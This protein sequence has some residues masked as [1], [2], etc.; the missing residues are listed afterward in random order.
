MTLKASF[1]RLLLGAVAVVPALAFAN[2]QAKAEVL[3]DSILVLDNFVL[4]SDDSGTPFTLADVELQ[5]ATNTANTGG[6]GLVSVPGSL[7]QLG[8]NGITPPGDV[9]ADVNLTGISEGAS[10]IGDDNYS[11]ALT[12]PPTSHFAYADSD[13]NGVAI[14][15]GA[16]TVG[17]T[18][19]TRAA[20]GLLT[21]DTG[22][23]NAQTGL[24]ASFR[25]IA[26]ED[27]ELWVDFDYFVDLVAF[28]STDPEIADA[29]A[30]TR[31][32]WSIQLTDNNTGVVNTL[33]P[34]EINQSRGRDEISDG[35]LTLSDSGHLTLFLGNLISGNLY[36]LTIT[37]QVFAQTQ[38]AL[39][40]IPEPSA[41][42]LFGSGLVILALFGHRFG[43]RRLT[44][45]D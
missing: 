36:G 19:Q 5:S 25:F 28:V 21:S 24:Q 45:P 17:V 34:D 11:P 14:D 8:T 35:T 4:A 23:A 40:A 33:S 26:V 22:D 37:H 31:S 15:V 39:Q 41:L 29:V 42:L 10:P 2:T 6:E 7:G 3:A 38:L 43:R 44:S 18:A 13:V 1:R 30:I 16:P 12:P 9:N 27:G 32:S 20:S